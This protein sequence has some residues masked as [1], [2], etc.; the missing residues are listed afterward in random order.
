MIVNQINRVFHSKQKARSTYNRMSR[1]YDLFAGSSERKFMHYG[2]SQIRPLPGERILEIGPGTGHG[3][4]SL[5][6][7]A[8][9]A[10]I[11]VGLDISEGMLSRSNSLIRKSNLQSSIQLHQGDG[12]KLPYSTNF[13]S[14]IF[15]C[16]TLELFDTPDIPLVLIECRRV[17]K[18]EGRIVIVCLSREQ[19]IPVLIYELFH[20]LAPS[21]IDCRPIFVQPFLLQSSFIVIQST[22]KKMWGLPVEI[23]SAGITNN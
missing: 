8:T 4:I 20:K 5:A 10:G 12:C 16:F 2:I 23:V 3:L 11:I 15:L 9:K 7:S 1:W 22:I 13:F 14:A 17:L 21:F 6:R 19:S 18:Q